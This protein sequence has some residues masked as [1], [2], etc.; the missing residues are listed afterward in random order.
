MPQE[1]QVNMLRAQLSDSD[2]K[3][4]L[5]AAYILA[6]RGLMDGR[7]VFLQALQHEQPGVRLQAAVMLG[8]IGASWAITPLG[9][10][11]ADGESYV[12][13]EVINALADIARAGVVPWL[14]KALQDDDEERRE[15]ARVCLVRVLGDAVPIMSDIE[16][17]DKDEAARVA[18]WWKKESG[19]FFD[20]LCY[21]RGEL[22]S[23]GNWIGNLKNTFPE[24]IELLVHR[25][26]IW[27]G[28][29]LGAPSSPDLYARWESWWKENSENFKTGHRYFYGHLIN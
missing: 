13:N 11:L 15:D 5:E 23:L 10:L 17:E 26:H 24:H 12:R 22:I 3:T 16:V 19:Y 9:E 29:E 14:I 18:V 8:N 27:T 20:S 28:L 6:Q 2:P 4:Q 7:T 1:E 21:Y 25:L